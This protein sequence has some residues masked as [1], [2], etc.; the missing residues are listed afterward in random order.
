MRNLFDGAMMAAASAF[1]WLVIAWRARCLKQ[2]A[3]AVVALCIC[4]LAMLWFAVLDQPGIRGRPLG[5]ISAFL[6]E[7]FG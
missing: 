4:L 2:V 6:V 5:P 1:V 3:F 7:K